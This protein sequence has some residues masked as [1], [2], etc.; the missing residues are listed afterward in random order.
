MHTHLSFDMDSCMHVLVQRLRIL[1]AD[2]VDQLLEA[3]P[4]TTLHLF[5]KSFAWC[6]YL[7][8]YTLYQPD[9]MNDC[10]TDLYSPIYDYVLQHHLHLLSIKE[11]KQFMRLL[12][13]QTI[14]LCL[15]KSAH[16]D[17]C[18]KQLLRRELE[19]WNHDYERLYEGCAEEKSMFLYRAY[20]PILL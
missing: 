19:V 18:I 5:R 7:R 4:S 14:T 13:R 15:D 8:Y 10:P 11:T 20:Q 12:E 2:A 17:P 6:L 3:R 1:P 9:H 16:I